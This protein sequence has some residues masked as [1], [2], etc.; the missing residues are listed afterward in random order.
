MKQL[1][2]ITLTAGL[3]VGF[4]TSGTTQRDSKYPNSNSLSAG[5]GSFTKQAEKFLT[6]EDIWYSS[7]FAPEYVSG[8]RSMSDGEH[9][10]TLERG[11]TGMEINKY[12]Y[13]SY[14]KV[15]TIVKSGDL[16]G[17]DEKPISIEDY[18]F[19]SLEDQILIATNITPIYRHSSKAY[20]YIYDIKSKQLTP[21][22]SMEGSQQSLATFSPDG[23]KVGFIR[24]NNIWIKNLDSGKEYA[25]TFDGKYNHIINGTTDWV[26]EEEFA[27]IEGFHWSPK[28]DKVAYYKINESNVKE[29][30][31]AMYGELYPDQ[32]RFK[33]PKAGE[34][35]S[36][37]S[38]HIYD[39]AS[40]KTRICDVGQETDQY[41]PRIKWTQDNNKLCILRM[42]RLQNKLDFLITTY[43]DGEESVP[44]PH[45]VMYTE[46]DKRY[47][48]IT[49]NLNFLADNSFLWTSE[50]DGYNHIYQ[51][52]MN[53]T[54]QQVTSGKWDVIALKGIDE[55]SGT[56]YFTSAEESPTQR[57][58]Y[59]IKLN[60]KSKTKLSSKKG[61][62]DAD[63]SSS[64]KYYINYHSD[65]NTPYYITMHQNSG[66]EI[67][68]LK[69]NQ[70]LKDAL[71]E[72]SLGRKEFF[73]FKTSEGVQ[74]NG[75]WIKPPNYV[76]GKKYP[77]FMTVYG[78]PGA[79]T[80]NDS[81]GGYNFLWHQLI[82]QQGYVVVSVDGRGT[83]HRGA[84]FKKCTYQ[85]L[86]KYETIDQ[87]EAAI[88]L[89]KQSFVDKTRIGIQGW[90]Y[91]GYMSS[92][93][94]TKGADFFKMA[95]AV[96][97]VTN[98]RY[99]DTIYTERYMRTPQENADGYDDNSPINHVD[100]MRGSYLLVH[101]S[102]D[103]NVHYQNT[104]EM[105]NAMVKANKQFD[106]FIYPDKNHGI[107]GGTTRLHLFTKMT[108]FIKAN[109]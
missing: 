96:A 1:I 9:F 57:H 69:D 27:F 34:E 92:L 12:A 94:L 50:Q 74:L 99:Y 5:K 78:G 56:I 36:L 14:K 8:V 90:S 93:C 105:I 103:D 98:W 24:D 25:I 13:K 47:V 45:Q 63:F 73:K 41:I 101:G 64:F 88:W 82:A 85:Q 20:Y 81:W 79:N 11:E 17:A 3:L 35:N 76:A 87:I 30:Q 77:V 52:S 66:K 54:A 22:S 72:Y 68:V 58:V 29:F 51:I 28:S 32:Y 83:G 26:Y 89:G 97:P 86:G 108:D 15:A 71:G 33:Y 40:K 65:A 75:W 102:A 21:L 6:N 70:K 107:Y 49:D 91:G 48:E 10:T 95:I 55:R 39:L 38:I 84:E 18:H 43:S 80:V 53:G 60:G 59:S 104:M 37:V 2:S 62:N 100:K 44:L 46:T 19:N 67:K 31:M 23:S 106:L 109:L 42:N 16:L 4:T 7:D 61:Q